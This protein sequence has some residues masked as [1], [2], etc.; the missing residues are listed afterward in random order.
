MQEAV[1]LEVEPDPAAARADVKT[2]Q[3]LDRIA[4]LA[5]RRPKRAEIMTADQGRRG[6][7]HALRIEPA[8][9]E[10]RPLPVE[11]AANLLVDDDVSI[12][13]ATRAEPRVKRRRHGLNPL[14]AGPRG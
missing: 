1:R 14:D 9:V 11:R 6:K 13:S 10:R 4:G 2:M 5:R 12:T 3:C 7:R 8:V